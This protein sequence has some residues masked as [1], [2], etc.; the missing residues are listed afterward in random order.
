MTAPR[1]AGVAVLAMVAAA[2][3]AGGKHT[4]EGAALI[5]QEAN[6][7]AAIVDGNATAATQQATEAAIREAVEQAAG[8]ILESDTVTANSQLVKDQISTHAQGYVH[9]YKVLA[10]TLE[11]GVAKVTVR[12]EVGRQALDR[13][14]VAIRG[15]VHRLENKK[16]V[17]FL[18]ETALR[19]DHAVTRSATMATVLTGAFKQ[20][21]WTLID[22]AFLAGKVQLA[23][24]VEQG[25]AQLRELGNTTR[26]DYI[27]YGTVKFIDE[28]PSGLNEQLLNGGYA[29][30]GKQQ[31]FIVNGSYDVGVFA[32]DSGSV[33][34]KLTETFNSTDPAAKPG[35]VRLIPESYEGYEQAAVGIIRR[36]KDEILSKVRGAVV[37]ALKSAE[38]DGR[39][40]VLKLSGLGSYARLK[41]FLADLKSKDPSIRGT[42]NTT[43]DHGSAQVDLR[44]VGTADELADRLG[45]I[46][47][48]KRALQV[49][50]VSGNVVEATFAR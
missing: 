42:E 39:R 44:F 25:A 32:T 37:D 41:D 11:G 9:G 28:E 14:L 29:G 50:G 26:A 35:E 4:G 22:P 38:L 8:V 43:F 5:V 47:F 18:D 2:Q 19:P 12:V 30:S 27:V 36:R 6:G 34:A 46:T 21:G 49:T 3:A 20:D 45:R 23:G 33:I 40:I 10:K 7:E 48:Q 16:L 13:D 17:I 31:Q 1:W 15:L 24:G